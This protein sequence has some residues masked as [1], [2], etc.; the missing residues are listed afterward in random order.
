MKN[1]ITELKDSQGGFNRK[2]DQAEERIGKCE[3]ESFEL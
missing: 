1:E 3:G 2:T